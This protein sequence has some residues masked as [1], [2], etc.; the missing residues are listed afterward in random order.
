MS[1]VKSFRL[2]LLLLGLEILFVEP[3]LSSEVALLKNG[4]QL[5]IETHR[6]VGDKILLILD[7]TDHLEF[8]QE[9]IESIVPTDDLTTSQPAV[10]TQPDTQLNSKHYTEQEIM[11]VIKTVAQKNR[12]AEGLLSS[13]IRVES[14]FNANAHSPRGAQGLMQLMPETVAVYKVK[15]SF[16]VRE[17]VEAGARYLRD[18]LQQFNQNLVLALAA[19]N[20]G[21]STVI[22]YKGVPPFPET[23]NYIRRVLDSR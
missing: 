22:S 6:Q 21:P 9:W 2:F 13:I 23:Q 4:R 3:G 11:Q 7:G 12:L 14:N 10:P 17:N 18:L 8:D 20:A 1:W 19:Y 16:D 15:D 5:V